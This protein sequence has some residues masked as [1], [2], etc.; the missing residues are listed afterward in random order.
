[1]LTA[2]MATRGAVGD[3]GIRLMRERLGLSQREVA[4]LA[5]VAEST[6]KRTE[7]RGAGHNLARIAAA[8]EEAARGHTA[9]RRAVEATGEPPSVMVREFLASLEALPVNEQKI[10]LRAFALGVKAMDGIDLQPSGGSTESHV[11]E[12]ND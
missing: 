9:V 4:T 6:V 7:K 12:T 5:G 11:D 3:S 1:M 2:H 8:L 10:A